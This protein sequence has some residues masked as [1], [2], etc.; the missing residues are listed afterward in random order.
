MDPSVEEARALVSDAALWPRVRDFLWDFAPQVHESWLEGLEREVPDAGREAVSSLV[1]RL[2]SSPRAKQFLLSSLGVEPFFHSFPRED[3]SRIAL[4]DGATLLEIA[5]W[6]GA[7]AC[8]PALRRVTDG[9]EVRALRAALPGVYPEVFGYTAY[10]GE[11]AS[12]P[13]SRADAETR[14]LADEVVSTGCGILLAAVAG[15]PAPLVARLQFKLPKNLCASAS[16]SEE[17]PPRESRGAVG[18]ASL[19]KLLKL[20]FPEAHSLCC[21]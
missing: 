6:L 9:A 3:G 20:K 4:L 8:A 12:T 1:S 2:A 14:S 17:E 15:L 10:F 16:A 13:P 5:K 21:S 11:G 7:L 18:P 19:S